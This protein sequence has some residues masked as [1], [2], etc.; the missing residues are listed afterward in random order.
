MGF[1][2]L[3]DQGRDALKDS[4]G[5]SA[6]II[7]P[8]S[9]DKTIVI[10]IVEH[11]SSLEQTD[12][13][14]ATFHRAVIVIDKADVSNLSDKFFVRFNGRKYAFQEQM[15]QTDNHEN[16]RVVAIDRKEITQGQFR[17]RRV[18]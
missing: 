6:V 18:P 15:K 9:A 12:N 10:T 8:G 7:P 1:E 14:E 11:N 13:G 17:T 4:L 2:G 16:W 3:M 5:E